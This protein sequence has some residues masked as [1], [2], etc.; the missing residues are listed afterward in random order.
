VHIILCVLIYVAG[1]RSSREWHSSC[2][3]FHTCSGT[4]RRAH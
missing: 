3:T 1:K 2:E 4:T